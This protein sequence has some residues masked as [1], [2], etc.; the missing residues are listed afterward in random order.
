MSLASSDIA[1]AA[2]PPGGWAVGVSG[3]ADSVALLLLLKDRRPDLSLHVVHL[4]HET[5]GEAS[6]GDARFVADLAA[7][8]GLPCTVAKLSDVQPRL[9]RVPANASS[10]YRAVRLELFRSVVAAHGLLGVLLAHHADDQ[11]ETVLLRLLRGSAPAG[12]VGMAADYRMGELRILRPLLAE[13]VGGATL[14]EYLRSANQ[15]WREDASNASDKYLR[16]RIRPI[17]RNDVELR[18][19]LIRLGEAA[20]AWRDWTI[21]GA[22]DLPAR[23]PVHTLAA[24]PGPLAREASRRWLVCVGAPPGALSEEVLERLVAMAAD[25]ATAARQQ[26]PGK[27]TVRRRAGTIAADTPR[28]APDAAL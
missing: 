7:R 16:N 5:R 23:F 1:L 6:T 4:D 11:A 19:A 21:A 27:L 17:L 10:R 28:Q 15:P 3:G 24:L 14:R 12:L 2:V 22:P 20:R 8:L 26:F 9:W 25:A 13:G 18:D